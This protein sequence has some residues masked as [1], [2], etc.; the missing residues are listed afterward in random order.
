MAQ[1]GR[2]LRI[3]V[4]RE[5]NKGSGPHRALSGIRTF[6]AAALAGVIAEILGGTLLISAV[7]L[8]TAAL[9]AIAYYRTTTD[10]PG[11]TIEIAPLTTSLLGGF[12]I[13]NPTPVDASGV[14]VAILLAAKAPMHRFVRTVLNNYEV[15]DALI[16]AAATFVVLPILPNRYLGPFNGFNPSI[17][18]RLAVLLMA[19]QGRSISP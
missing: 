9:L 17:V 4:E 18:W 1:V 8:G 14:A 15:N 19:I 16:L 13:G 5:R 11:L 6:A 3:G 12:A 7:A 2:S 10:D